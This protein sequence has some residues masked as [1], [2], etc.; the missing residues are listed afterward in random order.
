MSQEAS[1]T[2]WK[3]ASSG[4]EGIHFRRGKWALMMHGFVN[5]AYGAASGGR[6]DEMFFSTNMGMLM[7]QRRLGRGTL[8]VRVMTSLEPA[9][10][11]RGYPLLLQTGETFDGSTPLIDR[12]HPHDFFMELALTY[13]LA[14]PEDR[15]LFLYLAPAGEPAL[16]PPAFM[17]RPSG[18]DNPLAPISHHWLD[19]THISYGVVTAGFVQAPSLKIEV[20][21]FNGR[22]PDHR[23]WMLETPRLDSYSTRI[24][25][26]PTPRL[27]LQASFAELKSPEALHPGTDYQRLTASALF[28]LKFRG[29]DWHGT[30]AWGRNRRE[31]IVYRVTPGGVVTS[32]RKAITHYIPPG[33]DGP[34]EPF[35]RIF[36]TPTSLQ[37]AYLAEA[38]VKRGTR[39]TVFARFE[40]AHKDELFLS[41]NP[42]ANIVFNVQKLELGYIYDFVERPFLA[43]G[44]GVSGG[45]H[46]VPQGLTA[47]YGSQPKSVLI[48][49][50]AKLR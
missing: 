21:A 9:M 23:R 36:I 35:E 31:R 34:E 24:S 50:R 3:P 20:S 38:A 2:S 41:D 10:G 5:A 44:A 18:I 46:F 26:N 8:G 7:G 16:G 33:P 28:S 30:L 43:L 48:F 32:A 15:S 13:S 42:G 27:A 19:S 25:V 11:S 6:G 1:G 12:Q 4:M 49:G 39:H 17:H 45:V 40:R 22:E 47:V 37:S 14:L 29:L